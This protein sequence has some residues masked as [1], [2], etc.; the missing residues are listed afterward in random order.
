MRCLNFCFSL[1]L[2]TLGCASGYD[3]A[4]L[5]LAFSP[6]R[7]IK[8]QTEAVGPPKV[9]QFSSGLR[10]VVAERAPPAIDEG[11]L[12]TLLFEVL[13]AAQTEVPGK[14]VSARVGSLNIGP[15]VRYELKEGRV[16]SLIYY[17]PLEQR[18]A[19]AILTAPED[20]YGMLET[21]VERSLSAL[22]VRR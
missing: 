4:T 7:G 8:L 9:A 2:A 11:S 18:F 17:I 14:Q 16:R 21:Q 10:L 19:L 12:E 20:R 6:P 22:A 3:S 5:G 1:A 15:V 13:S